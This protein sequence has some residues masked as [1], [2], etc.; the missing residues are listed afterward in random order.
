MY[1][2]FK[3][4]KFTGVVATQ[5]DDAGLEYHSIPAGYD[6]VQHTPVLVEGAVQLSNRATSNLAIAPYLGLVDDVVNKDFTIIGLV[7]ASPLFD[8]GRKV[9]ASYYTDITETTEVVKKT[10]TDWYDGADWKGLDITFEWMDTNGDVALTKTEKKPLNIEE[11]GAMSHKRRV[12]Q[13]SSLVARSVGTPIEGMVAAIFTHYKDETLEYQELGTQTLENAINNETDP[14]MVG[15]LNTVV[16]MPGDP[17]ATVKD[18][19]LY[20]IT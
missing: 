20:E 6:P 12:R 19:I 9:S 16:G 7:K 14:T 1:L 3:H 10:F 2:E 11:R 4:G 18:S 17:T 13:V 8:K 5:S 15:Y